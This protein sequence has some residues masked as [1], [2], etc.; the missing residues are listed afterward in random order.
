MPYLSLIINNTKEEHQFNG[1]IS[2]LTYVNDISVYI[3]EFHMLSLDKCNSH[4]APEE[5]SG[6]QSGERLA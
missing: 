3:V 4:F 5:G 2:T 6:T 1:S